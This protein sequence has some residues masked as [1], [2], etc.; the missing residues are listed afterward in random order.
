MRILVLRGG[1]LGDFIVTLPALRALQA[2]WPQARLEL[3]GNRRAATLG[4][5]DGCVHAVHDQ[6]EARWAPLFDEP[7]LPPAL[8]GW[9]QG[10]D[11]I[12]SYWPDPDGA[13]ARHFE[14][15]RDRFIAGSSVVTSRP[16]ARHFLAPLRALGCGSSN[17]A[18]VIRF[19][20][21]T[22]A[23]ARRRLGRL[24]RFVAVH[25]GSG[26]AGKTWPLA[27]WHE[28]ARRLDRP[29]LWI[30]G[31]ADGGLEPPAGPPVV[32]A[33]EWPLAVLGAALAQSDF[34]LGQDTGVSHLA[35]AAGA[36]GVLLFGP[37]DPAVWAPPTSRLTLLRAPDERMTSLTVESVLAAAG[38]GR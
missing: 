23:E 11:L 31:E 10:F 36:R 27:R 38:Q 32:R 16:A 12:V 34:Y 3:V 29:L 22:E 17:P 1:A 26:S 4:R 6:Q 33:E 15:R 19:P 37:T 7:P 5:V 21:D 20:A 13:L 14:S 9:L 35:A 30:T 2:R 24:E 8:A 28:V 25:A 18:P